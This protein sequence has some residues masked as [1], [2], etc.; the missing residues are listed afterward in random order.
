MTW[1]FVVSTLSALSVERYSRVIVP[2]LKTTG[3]VYVFHVV[4]PSLL[5]CVFATPERVSVADSVA[6]TLNEPLS[7]SMVIGAV[8]SIFTVGEGTERLLPALSIAVIAPK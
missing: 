7:K 6:V 3:V 8:L 2:P 5:Y 1:D 4:P